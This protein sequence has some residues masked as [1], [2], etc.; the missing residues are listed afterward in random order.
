MDLVGSECVGKNEG[1]YMNCIIILKGLME[2]GN[3]VVCGIF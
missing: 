2:S 1:I 3:D